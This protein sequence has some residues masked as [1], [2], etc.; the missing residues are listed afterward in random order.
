M[1]QSMRYSV[2]PQKDRRLA[3]CNK[4]P[5]LAVTTVLNFTQTDVNTHR[6]D[7]GTQFDQSI[8]TAILFHY[9]LL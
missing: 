6:F 3:I 9:L 2:C 4:S 7:N 8:H 1:S 5:H